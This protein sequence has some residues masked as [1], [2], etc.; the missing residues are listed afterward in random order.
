MPIVEVNT[1]KYF[2]DVTRAALIPVC[3]PINVIPLTQLWFHKELKVH[4][5]PAK[6]C[7]EMK[8]VK[9]VIEHFEM[10]KVDL[11]RKR[12][13]F[14]LSLL[15][16]NHIVFGIIP[17]KEDIKLVTTCQSEFDKATAYTKN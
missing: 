5:D 1:Q 13:N 17:S 15:I 10:V 14:Y 9:A 16:A 2:Y 6:L 7:E 11:N 12:L 8:I 4:F 3:D